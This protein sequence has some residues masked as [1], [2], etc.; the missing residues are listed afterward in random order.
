[1]AQREYR[2]LSCR[3]A[4]ADCD[5]LLR[6]ETL[7]EVMNIAS[8]HACRVHQVCEITPEMKDKM[9][10][11]AKSVWCEKECYGS[12]IMESSGMYWGE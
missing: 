8:E 3:D 1:M 9:E 11:L 6:A 4:G 10:S 2:Q 12:P 5:F 7:D